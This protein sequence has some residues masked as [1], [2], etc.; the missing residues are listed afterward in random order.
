[1]VCHG[2]LARTRPHTKY[3]TEF[4]LWMSFGGFFGGVFNALIAPVVFKELVEYPLAIVLAC[5]LKPNLKKKEEKTDK[6][7]DQY[8]KPIRAD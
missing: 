2:E 5:L 4:Y 3:L 1:M 8:G 7:L 6:I